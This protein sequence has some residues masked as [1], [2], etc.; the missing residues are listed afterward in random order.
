[1]IDLHM[2][3]N[4]S[5][6][7]LSPQELIDLSL[8]KGLNA[9]AVTDHDSIS[10]I[11]PAIKYAKG[12]SLEV[13]P[14]IEINCNE[15]KIGYEE[16]EVVGLFVEHESRALVKFVEGTK[17]DRLEQKKKIVKKLQGLG[18]DI[19]FEELEQYAK[20]SLGRPHIARLLMEKHPE[21]VSSIRD[22]FEKYL[23]AGKAAYVD[24]ESKPGIKEAISVIRK[25]NGLTFLAHPG[26]FNK[27]DSVKLI[28]FVQQQ[29]GQGIETYYPY[30]IICPKLKIGEKENSEITRF[31]QK[32]AKKEGLLESGGSDFHGGD[33]ETINTVK[34][35]DAVLD[36]LKKEHKN[37]Q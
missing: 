13:V 20:G 17:Q 2:H 6:G 24:R 23:G 30:H 32:I 31:Y 5:D 22:A 10:G 16:V 4:A 36:K 26:I 33:R 34:I 29:G 7:K 12:K 11:A 15:S 18:F 27:K 3:T 19:R 14:G 8:E 37:I 35:P 21:K 28:E 1:M 9:I 25:A